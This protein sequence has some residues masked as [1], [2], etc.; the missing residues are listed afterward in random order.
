V[1][2]RHWAALVCWSLGVLLLG[3]VA[4]GQSCAWRHA[5]ASPASPVQ[6]TNSGDVVPITVNEGA[7]VLAKCD[8]MEEALA[9]L[10][11]I[12]SRVAR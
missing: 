3:Y 1:S 9:L 8:G 4:G 10:R 5:E 12:Q 2:P 7:R 6:I 11:T